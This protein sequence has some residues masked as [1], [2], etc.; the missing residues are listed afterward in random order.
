MAPYTRIPSPPDFFI[1]GIFALSHKGESVDARQGACFLGFNCGA[2]DLLI[3]AVGMSLAETIAPLLS[4]S[5]AFTIY[6][7][8]SRPLEVRVV[9]TKR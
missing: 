3:V 7:E 8:A 2:N 9:F 5:I 1:G 4:R 6:E